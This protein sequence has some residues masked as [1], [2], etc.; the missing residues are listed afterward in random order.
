MVIAETI[1]S[2]DFLRSLEKPSKDTWQLVC[3]SIL[4]PFP[5]T[6]VSQPLSTIPYGWTVL[7]FCEN[8]ILRREFN[9]VL[10]VALVL[11]FLVPDWTM[12]LALV[13]GAF[14]GPSSMT[15]YPSSCSSLPKS[16][17]FEAKVTLLLCLFFPYC[18]GMVPCLPSVR[19]LE[20][21]DVVGRLCVL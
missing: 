1:G 17:S 15:S 11:L 7:P 5:T 4:H 6:V 2:D 9:E 8:E 10:L 20:L 14:R 18:S 21:G 19:L 12:L 3:A 16:W 13:Q